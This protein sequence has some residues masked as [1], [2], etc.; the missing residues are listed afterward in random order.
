MFDLPFPVD[1]GLHPV[2]SECVVYAS[3]Y[4]SIHPVFILGIMQN[5]NG[6]I[7][8]TNNYKF[9]RHDIGPM[10]IN[11]IHLPELNKYGISYNQIKNNGCMNVY[12]GTYL[13]KKEIIRYIK[14]NPNADI[15]NDWVKAKV[16]SNYHSRT[17]SL[18]EIYAKKVIQNMYA[19]PAAWRDFNCAQYNSCQSGL[20]P[21]NTA[22]QTAAAS[23]SGIQGG[24]QSAVQ[25]GQQQAVS[26]SAQT[27]Y[28][29]DMRTANMQQTAV[30][31][32]SI[33]YAPYVPLKP[34]RR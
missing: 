29:A 11:T 26:S 23:Q 27:G 16:I 30:Q 15:S 24:A 33:S 9:N 19:L 10:Q 31:P 20:N 6:K 34:Y 25:P 2:T 14:N 13:I 1:E 18:N 17:P 22:A 28:Q 3:N 4:F 21:R 5:E 7:G 8:K 32:Q 12:A